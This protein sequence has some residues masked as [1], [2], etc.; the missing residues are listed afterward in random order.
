MSSN[1]EID[2]ERDDKRDDDVT[3]TKHLIIDLI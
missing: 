1:D 2:D 3:E